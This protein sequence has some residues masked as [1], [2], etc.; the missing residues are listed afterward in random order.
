MQGISQDSL[1]VV[2][3]ALLASA[4]DAAAA[5]A[6][7][8]RGLHVVRTASS[9]LPSADS[10]QQALGAAGGAA[11]GSETTGDAELVD[12]SLRSRRRCL[13][14]AQETETEEEESEDDDSFSE[15]GSSGSE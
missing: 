1:Q 3:G 10:I 8:G 5:S 14:L 6:Y 7:A 15:E 13:E 9:Y 12:A 4:R 2:F 11:G